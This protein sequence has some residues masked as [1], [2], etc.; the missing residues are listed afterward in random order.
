MGIY[1]GKDRD[2]MR[3]E[4]VCTNKFRKEFIQGNTL[5]ELIINPFLKPFK[6]SKFARGIGHS[7][8]NLVS[9]HIMQLINGKKLSAKYTFLHIPKTMDVKDTVREVQHMLLFSF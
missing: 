8:C 6:I 3:I 1:T 2:K 4:T 7:Y 5:Q 9:W